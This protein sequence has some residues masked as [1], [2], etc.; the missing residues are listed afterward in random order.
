M[1][2]EELEIDDTLQMRTK[3][4]IDDITKLLELSIETFFLDSRWE[5]LFTKYWKIYL[6]A[7][8]RYFICI[9]LTE[10]IYSMTIISSRTILFSAIS[11]S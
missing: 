1:V 11:S 5:D 7:T 2:K 8:S 9:S 10:L 3:W 6:Q 4:E